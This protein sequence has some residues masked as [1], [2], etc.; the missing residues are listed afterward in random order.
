MSTMPAM[1]R[2]AEGGRGVAFL[3]AMNAPLTRN[4]TKEMSVERFLLASNPEGGHRFGEFP[5]SLRG[6]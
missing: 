6:G 4:K 3:N 5:S 1:T 2:S